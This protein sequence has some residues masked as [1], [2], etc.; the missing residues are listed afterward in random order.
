[1][2]DFETL[3][4]PQ[5]PNWWLLAPPGL[6]KAAT[7]KMQTPVFAGSPEDIREALL[8]AI[9]REPR[10]TLVA[11]DEASGRFA[12]TAKT[13][14]MGFVDDVDVRILSQ[15]PQRTTFALYS[16]SRVGY[17]DLG[18]NAARGLRILNGVAAR[19]QRVD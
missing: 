1:M 2:I 3:T 6:C 17:S 16:R 11:Q 5:R 13:R 4:P 7:P 15:G 14:L 12:F 19:A 18:V 8:A 10:T 9:G